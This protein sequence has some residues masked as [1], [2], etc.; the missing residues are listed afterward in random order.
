[1]GFGAADLLGTGRAVDAVA[2]AVEA[3]PGDADRVV[4]AGRED[5]FV[6]QLLRFGGFGENFGIEGVVGIGRDDGDVEFADGTFLDAFGDAAREMGEE[7][8]GVIESFQGFA[9][10]DGF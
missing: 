2:G 4:G 8:G 10:R 6:I 5:E 1:M 9:G 3:D 7:I